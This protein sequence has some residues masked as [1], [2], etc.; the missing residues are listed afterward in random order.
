MKTPKQLRSDIQTLTTHLSDVQAALLRRADI[1][2]ARIGKECKRT[3]DALGVLLKTQ[4]VPDEYKVAVVGRFKAGKSYFVNELLGN[5]LASEGVFAET[6]AITTF[7]H[8]AEVKANISLVDIATWNKLKNLHAEDPK[9]V[10]AHRVRNW[11]DF[12][13]PKKT[14]EGE[15][16]KVFDLPALERQYVHDGGFTHTLTLPANSTKKATN[17]FRRA[18]KEF[19][20]STSPLHCLVDKIDITAPAEILDQGV[21][22]ID[23]PGLDD[24]ER[25]RV[26]LTEKV[27]ADVDAV[28]F[29]TKS[30]ASYGQ[31]E[32][33]FLLTLLRKGT[34]RQLI[35][36]ITQ[37]DE[38]YSKILKDAEG[39]DEEPETIAQCI[40]RERSLITTAIAATLKDLT[41]DDNLQRYQEQLGD[42][43]IA[44][45]S[46]SLHRDWKE[47]KTLPFVMDA[48]DPGGVQALNTRLLAL[49]RTES[50]LAQTAENILNGGRN[51]LLD[52]QSVLIAKLRALHNTTNKEVAEQKLGTFRDEF[53]QS[54][55]RFE[56]AIEQQIKVLSDRLVRQAKLDTTLLDF[57]GALADQ[58]LTALEMDDVCKHWRTRRSGYWGYMRGLQGNV[59]NLI[60]PKVQQLLGERTQFFA[61]YGKHFEA[62]LMRLAQDSERI[63][64][65]LD[66]GASVPLDVTG[67]LQVSLK[68]S[69]ERAQE[70]IAAEEQNVLQ[71]LDDFVSDEVSERISARRRVV[72][73]IWDVGT[74]VRQNL[75]VRDFYREIKTMLKEALRSHLT[76]SCHSFGEFLQEEA[77]SAPRDALNDVQLLLEQAADNIVAATTDHLAELNESA[78]SLIGAID[79]EVQTT[80]QLTRQLQALPELAALPQAASIESPPVTQTPPATVAKPAPA[81]SQPVAVCKPDPDLPPALPSITTA[82]WCDQV[83]Q[84]ATVLMDRLQ[85][86][87]GTTGWSYEKLFAPRF[88]AGALRLTLVDPRLSNPHQLRYL[89][90]LLLHVAE[91]AHPKEIE[92]VTKFSPDESPGVQARVIQ[93]ITSDLFKNYGVALTVRFDNSLH[94]RWLA[95]DNGVLFKL[96]RGLDVY[97]PALGLAVHRPALRRVRATTIDVFVAPGH[98]LAQQLQM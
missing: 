93:D 39:N 86:L 96:G 83:Q 17:D 64:E 91:C 37:I 71:L 82:D 36:V 94:D 12:A 44:F 78:E 22:L 15:P 32:K 53:G 74:V 56:G 69:F 35:V 97:K 42:V 47:H 98:P 7:R 80:L 21:L 61:D 70:R 95:L 28:L 57:I 46:A 52:L 6:A 62:Q 2:V 50:R 76:E 9:Q 67:R 55:T 11:T 26:S 85:L 90:E 73:D 54:G 45:T 8:G 49:L 59:A 75:E 77:K 68:R 20:S 58:P 27:V 79:A 33:D 10:D 18:L 84:Q 65:R 87:E 41:Q 63:A 13:T 92:V 43:P 66:L 23:T 19:T 48:A 88:L 4:Q 31:S 51:I 29:L 89:Q 24:T 14:K 25:F 38:T 16:D 5:K 81:Q 30:G 40:A 72:T 34:V 1:K 3:A 60:F